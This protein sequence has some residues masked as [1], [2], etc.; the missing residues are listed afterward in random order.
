MEEI[1]F[2]DDEPKVLH[3]LKLALFKEK[4]KL[5]F[6]NSATEALA[7]LKEKDISIVISDHK[8]PGMS[9]VD[10]LTHIKKISPYSIRILLTG[11]CDHE[12]TIKSINEAQ[13]HLFISKPFSSQSLKKVI[14]NALNSY[15]QERLICKAFNGNT[16]VIQ[17]IQNFTL[18]HIKHKNKF[19]MSH[20]LN[21]GMKLLDDLKADSGVLLF[22]KGHILTQKDL[23]AIQAYTISNKIPV[24]T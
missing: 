20:N 9:G 21:A 17:A 22:K 14:R 23:S 2:I 15:Q 18:N 12:S 16:Q 10:L 7:I 6:A 13:I 1:L 24:H 19:L 4:Y 3:S 8:M 5:Y 11:E